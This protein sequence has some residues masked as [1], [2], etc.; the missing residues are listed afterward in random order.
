MTQSFSPIPFPSYKTPPINEVVCGMRFTTPN[1]LL[2][3]HI[4][5]LWNKI[6]DDYPNIKHAAP[7]SSDQGEVPIDLATGFPLQRIWFINKSDDQ[8]IQFQFN[9]F[10]FNWRHKQNKYP[11]YPQV[12]KHF[13]ETRNIIKAFFKENDFGDL[14]PIEYELNYINHIPKGNGWDKIDDLPKMFSDFNWKR[15]TKRFLP[16]PE[17]LGWKTEFLLPN[18]HGRL[19][20]TLKMAIR[21]EDKLP[22]II[23]GLNARGFNESSSMNSFR[24]WFDEAHEWIVKGFTD[25]TTPAAHKVWEREK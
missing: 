7:I 22:L 10:Y 8:L 12:I 17:K 9:R 1:K 2:I 14:L 5:L 3:P 21:T 19:I 18:N 16:N 4:G 15:K 24:E 25:L 23:F 20:V 13:E 6:S 11:R